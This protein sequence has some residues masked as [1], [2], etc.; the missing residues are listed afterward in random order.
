MDVAGRPLASRVWDKNCHLGGLGVTNLGNRWQESSVQ[1]PQVNRYGRAQH[2][3]HPQNPQ[4][5]MV[6]C[7]IFMHQRHIMVVL[8]NIELS[9][10][11]KEQCRRVDAGFLTW[12]TMA[13]D[14]HSLNAPSLNSLFECL[15][16]FIP[17]SR[18]KV[19]EFL[20]WNGR[21]WR[22]L[23]FWCL[24]RCIGTTSFGC[25]TS[26]SLGDS[27][28]DIN[29]AFP[30]I[31][32]KVRDT[33]SPTRSAGGAATVRSTS[34]TRVRPFTNACPCSQ[35]PT[36]FPY[37]L[38]RLRTMWLSSRKATVVWVGAEGK[39]PKDYWNRQDALPQERLE[40]FQERIQV[41]L[42]NHRI[43]LR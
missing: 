10:M 38:Y 39:T 4:G 17:F 15:T 30:P 16:K 20:M 27:L 2:H 18:Q 3:R 34:N 12:M 1:P 23:T 42:T 7:C 22:R 33:R 13:A 19:C 24:L 5:N 40:T 8:E 29:I 36:H 6:S 26:H 14:H 35:R 9:W 25:V 21:Y 28:T 32:Y 37:R 31:A 43:S 11:D 41:C